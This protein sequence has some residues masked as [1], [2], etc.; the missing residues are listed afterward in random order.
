[1]RQ[2][3]RA[4]QQ[5]EQAAAAKQRRHEEEIKEEESM[6]REKTIGTGAWLAAWLPACLDH[7]CL[8]SPALCL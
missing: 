7:S 5:R 1:M 3:L 2:K 6:V 4:K 8:C